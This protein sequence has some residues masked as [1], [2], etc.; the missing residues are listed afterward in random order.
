MKVK[1]IYRKY[2]KKIIYLR[3]E[4]IE[5]EEVVYW[6]ASIMTFDLKI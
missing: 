4:V 2:R 1:F 6:E 5:L 3:Y